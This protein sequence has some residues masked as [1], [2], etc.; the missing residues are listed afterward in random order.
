MKPW[1]LIAS[2]RTPDQ[3]EMTLM[4]HDG[5]YVILAGGRPLM[6]SRVHGSEE[7]LAAVG[8]RRA[9]GLPAPSVLVGGLGMGFTLRATLDL[10]PPTASV[11]VSELVPDVVAWNREHLG[12]LTNHPLGDR[13]VAL[14]PRDVITTLTES[15]NRFDAVL[16]D[17]DNGPGA[18]TVSGNDWLY[19]DR[20]LATIR[21]SLRRAGVIAVWS[22]RDN[23]PFERRLRR[24]G[25]QVEVEHIRARLRHGGS[26]HAIVVG[27]K[28]SEGPRR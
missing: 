2:T 19:G 27:H 11:L 14:D 10:L 20:G 17:V 4:R 3:E 9:Q 18:F 26:R 1:E 28:S 5:E 12:Y 8:C 15:T 6:S 16:L 23:S 25:F 24:A 7:A 13:R 22:A 21:Q